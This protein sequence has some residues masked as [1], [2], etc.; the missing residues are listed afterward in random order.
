[1]ERKSRL[2][3][4]ARPILA[5]LLF[6][7]QVLSHIAGE[8]PKPSPAVIVEGLILAVGLVAA[9]VPRHEAARVVGLGLLMVNP[10]VFGLMTATLGSVTP[11]G[12]TG[13][14]M[15]GMLGFSWG[16][17]FV[18]GYW[19]NRWLGAFE[20]GHSARR[21]STRALVVI[22]LLLCSPSILA[23]LGRLLLQ[24]SYP[25][26]L[27][28]TDTLWARAMVWVM[29]VSAPAALLGLGLLVIATPIVVHLIRT[30]GLSSAAGRAA[31]VVGLLALGSAAL[32]LN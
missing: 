11:Y 7:P 24:V 29:L 2:R 20:S 22:V 23:G 25:D 4:S 5:L 32:W 31:T 6:L 8:W 18:F 12:R 14:E 21:L 27:I 28:P 9:V 1:M 26:G 10:S 13:I 15:F 19:V 16:A 30:R 17:A 3:A